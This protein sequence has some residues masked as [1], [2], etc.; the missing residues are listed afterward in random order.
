[1]NSCEIVTAPHELW[2][3]PKRQILYKMNI[4]NWMM[5]SDNKVH[6][7]ILATAID[8]LT[9]ITLYTFDRRNRM[10][11]STDLNVTQMKVIDGGKDG[12]FVWVLT[13]CDGIAENLAYSTTWIY[14]KN[15]EMLAMSRHTKG[16]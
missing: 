6:S 14:D 2:R 16:I 13:Q 11:V 4:G 7:G 8:D 1:M 10:T 12:D 3:D 15:F 5:N 9:S